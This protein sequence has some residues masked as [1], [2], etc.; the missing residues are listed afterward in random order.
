VNMD[1][2]RSGSQTSDRITAGSFS[3]AGAT[4]NV[5]NLGPNLVTD[6]VYQL[7]SGPVTVFTTVNLP[8]ATADNSITYVWENNLAV[9]GT[10]KVLSGASPVDPTPTDIAVTVNGNTLELSWPSTH[11]GW[12]LQAQTNALSVGLN[13]TWFD[14]AG[15]EN[16]NQVFLPIDP[17]NPTVFYRLTLP[18][19]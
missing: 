2:N 4:L 15:S 3:G 12:T 14:V 9:D 18:Q 16:T 11:T 5:T 13:G 17:A 1:L 6:D 10:I 7:F 19:P 8:V